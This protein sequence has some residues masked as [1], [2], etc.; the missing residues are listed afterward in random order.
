M[1]TSTS[2]KEVPTFQPKPNHKG[3]EPS[4]ENRN[5]LCG[6]QALESVPQVRPLKTE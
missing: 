3:L 1:T 5:S 4:F 2:N 6:P